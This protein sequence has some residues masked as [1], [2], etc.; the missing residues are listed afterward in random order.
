MAETLEMSPEI[1]AALRRGAAAGEIRAVAV[2]QG[3]RTIAADGIRRAAEGLVSLGE[4]LSL[5]GGIDY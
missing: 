4:V 3:M 5:V 2:G 1:E